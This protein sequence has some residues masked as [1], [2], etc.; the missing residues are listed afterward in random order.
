MAASVLMV[1]V[2]PLAACAAPPTSAVRAS[3]PAPIPTTPSGSVSPN[4]SDVPTPTPTWPPHMALPTPPPEMSRADEA[5]AI[6][7]AAYFLTQLYPYTISTHD[8]SAWLVMSNQDCKFCASAIAA[9][10][11]LVNRGEV[12]SFAPFRA[13][14]FSTEQ[15]SPVAFGVFFDLETGPD[16]TFDSG[17]RVVATRPA[18]HGRAS[19]AIVLRERQWQVL[20]VQ[21]DR[22]SK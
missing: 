6:A 16:S 19:I 22:I 1:A 10:A 20:G 11:E 5:G 21:L 13:T 8:T 4:T 15:R 14:N 7:A 2:A 3:E 18:T 9:S 12:V 17:G